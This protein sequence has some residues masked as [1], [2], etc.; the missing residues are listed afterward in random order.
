MLDALQYSLQFRWALHHQLPLHCLYRR[1]VTKFCSDFF[2]TWSPSNEIT[3]QLQRAN[4]KVR[5]GR[6]APSVEWQSRF[7]PDNGFAPTANI[8]SCGFQSRGGLHPRTGSLSYLNVFEDLNEHYSHTERCSLGIMRLP[9]QN[10]PLSTMVP[11]NSPTI[12]R[13]IDHQ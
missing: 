5:R 11:K 8:P 6:S 1:Q 13:M 3:N 12:K 7:C 9:M 2:Q 10:T 4:F